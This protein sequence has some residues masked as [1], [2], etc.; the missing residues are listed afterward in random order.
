[1]SVVVKFSNKD[2]GTDVLSNLMKVFSDIHNEIVMVDMLKF[3][4]ALCVHTY[5]ANYSWD[6]LQYLVKHIPNKEND[7]FIFDFQLHFKQ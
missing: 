3:A 4:Y 5:N 6:L 7:N 2:L 1:L